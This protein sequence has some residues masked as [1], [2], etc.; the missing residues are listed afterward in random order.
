MDVVDATTRSRM[1]AGIKGKNTKPELIVRKFLHRLGLRYVLHSKLDGRPDILLPR[2]KAV[3]FVHGCF[4]HRHEGCKYATVPKTNVAFWTEK[5][6]LNRQRDARNQANLRALGWRV[7]VVWECETR[8][9]TLL[10]TLADAI[11]AE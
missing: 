4:W 5:L 11:R 6:S 2:R 7:F 9:A 1:M 10:A 3:V 8:D